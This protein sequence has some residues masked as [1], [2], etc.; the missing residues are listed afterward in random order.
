VLVRGIA[1]CQI[2]FSKPES[3]EVQS[4]HTNAWRDKAGVGRWSAPTVGRAIGHAVAVHHGKEARGPGCLLVGPE[5]L[6]PAAAADHRRVW[7]W[8]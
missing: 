5:N 7:W 3:Q 4:V 6:G 8:C 1:R 2:N